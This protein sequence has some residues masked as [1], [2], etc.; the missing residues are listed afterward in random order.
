MLAI[1]Q[2]A[3]HAVDELVSQPG[4]P[5]E[6]GLRIAVAT[7]TQNGGGPSSDLELTVV[8]APE[9]DDEELAEHSIYLESG[10]DAYLDG[11]VLDAELEGNEV[12]FSLQPRIEAD[13][14]D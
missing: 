14:A 12:R 9:P 4:L 11:M 8:P 5:D 6:A 3:A 13:G 1:T 2:T 7:V 10:I